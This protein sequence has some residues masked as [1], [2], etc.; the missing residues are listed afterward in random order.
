MTNTAKPILDISLSEKAPATKKANSPK[1]VAHKLMA[2]KVPNVFFIYF[3]T[4]IRLTNRANR[5]NEIKIRLV[6]SLLDTFSNSNVDVT[7]SSIRTTN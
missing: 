6:I 2:N 5:P 3:H 4:L 1:S 7:T